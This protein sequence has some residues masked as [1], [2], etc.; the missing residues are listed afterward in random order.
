MKKS[1]LSKILAGAMSLGLISGG[2]FTSN[3]VIAA[4]VGFEDEDE[5]DDDEFMKNESGDQT[6]NNVAKPY[7][8]KRLA[9]VLCDA[10]IGP[11]L[12]HVISGEEGEGWLSFATDTACLIAKESVQKTS[13]AVE[14]YNQYANLDIIKE[15]RTEKTVSRW[16]GYQYSINQ[17]GKLI[18]SIP[19]FKD[20]V[21][22]EKKELEEVNKALDFCTQYSLDLKTLIKNFNSITGTE[23]NYTYAQ[24]AITDEIYNFVKKMNEC[25][26]SAERAKSIS[27]FINLARKLGWVAWDGAKFLGKI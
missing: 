14:G 21:I 18:K 12:P 22:L 20:T 8:L 17:E 27:E 25:E 19:N 26:K 3:N 24:K 9:F 4:N 10:F 11:W 23:G 15:L 7:Q 5:Y 2:S 16:P 6:P 13:A 1:L